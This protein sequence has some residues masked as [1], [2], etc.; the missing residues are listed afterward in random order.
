MQVKEVMNR[1]IDVIRPDTTLD[2]A[3]EKMQALEV[4]VLP[5]CDGDRLV[6]MLSDRD[7]NLRAVGDDPNRT[8]ARDAMTADLVYC[9]EDQDVEEAAKLMERKQLRRLVVLT[10]EKR[11]A[12]I[13][14]LGDLAGR[15]GDPGRSAAR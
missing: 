12:G 2:E 11:L 13:L 14:S 7:V 10:R 6:G 1:K 3:A 4:G 5:V 15:Y 8:H 9:F